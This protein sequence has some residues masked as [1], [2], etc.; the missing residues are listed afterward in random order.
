M[1]EGECVRALEIVRTY[2]RYRCRAARKLMLG[3]AFLKIT[4]VLDT[5]DYFVD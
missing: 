4:S 1:S 2:A 3:R 5:Q